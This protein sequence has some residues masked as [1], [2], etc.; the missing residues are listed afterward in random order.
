MELG[1]LVK[2]STSF[3]PQR[4][5]QTEHTIQNLE[6]MLRACAID[7]KGSL[8]EHLTLVE[9]SYNNSYHSSISMAPFK[10]LYG[11]RL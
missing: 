8:D 10:A 6:Y 4:D 1:T 11:K 7:F 5:G 3:H 2:L 9:F